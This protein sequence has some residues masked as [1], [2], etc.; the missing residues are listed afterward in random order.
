MTHKDL[1]MPNLNRL[2]S[3]FPTEY[4]LAPKTYLL[5]DVK[6]YAEFL[7]ERMRSKNCL[8]MCRPKTASR[9]RG[10]SMVKN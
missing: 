10:V 5:S 9:G 8:W 2:R 6:Q 4:D 1:L 3:Q 7:Q